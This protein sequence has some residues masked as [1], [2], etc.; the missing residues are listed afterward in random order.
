[1]VGSG[2]SATD[3]GTGFQVGK[4]MDGE[5]EGSGIFEDRSEVAGP[6]GGG[7]VVVLEARI[8]HWVGWRRGVF[9]R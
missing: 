9:V 8:S 3:D 1:M 6:E 2:A 4:A 5:G 7:G